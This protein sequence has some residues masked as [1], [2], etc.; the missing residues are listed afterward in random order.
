MEI[1]LDIAREDLLFSKF[2]L[3]FVDG[4]IYKF[5]KDSLTMIFDLISENYH[6]NEINIMGSLIKWINIVISIF[7]H[8]TDHSH[9][10]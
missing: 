9:L 4:K 7:P 5:L 2:L 3:N 1:Q 8:F 10:W 6:K